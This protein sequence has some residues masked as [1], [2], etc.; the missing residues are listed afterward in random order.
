MPRQL[1]IILIAFAIALLLFALVALVYALAPAPVLR[2]AIPLEPTL[3]VPPG[4][5]G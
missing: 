3:L 2:D 1:R 5:G 4:G